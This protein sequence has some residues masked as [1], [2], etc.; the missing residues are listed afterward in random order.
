MTVNEEDGEQLL[1][2]EL[3]IEDSLLAPRTDFVGRLFAHK[4][5]KLQLLTW[6][7]SPRRMR[8]VLSSSRNLP[9]RE[10]SMNLCALISSGETLL[11]LQHS[12]LLI[13]QQHSCTEPLA[14]SR[15]QEEEEDE[16]E[17]K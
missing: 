16:D 6:T 14:F 9:D 10:A 12:Q 1:L 17:L 7:V 4:L 3:F 5:S 15:S 11:A 8:L 2:P 13:L